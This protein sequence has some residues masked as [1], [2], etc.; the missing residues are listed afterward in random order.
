MKF[1]YFRRWVKI[2]AFGDPFWTTSLEASESLYNFMAENVQK[3]LPAQEFRTGEAKCLRPSAP[4]LTSLKIFPNATAVDFPPLE[5]AAP[6]EAAIRAGH[7][8]Y[9]FSAEN[10]ILFM[11]DEQ[12]ATG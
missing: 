10:E 1:P 6:F 12:D 4:M 5:N 8:K 11:K 2:T 3:V 7:G 9:I